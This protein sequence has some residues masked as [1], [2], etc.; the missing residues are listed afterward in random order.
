MT[1]KSHLFDLPNELFFQI[2][3]HL[4]ASELIESF[5]NLQSTRLRS[6]LSSFIVHLDLSDRPD[7]WLNEY[8]PRVLPE[9]S[10][11]SLRCEDRQINRLVDS[12]SAMDLLRSMEIRNSD[13][14]TDL[15]KEALDRVRQRLKQLKIIFTSTHGQGDIAQHLFQ[16]DASI[17][18][19]I[20]TGRFLYFQPNELNR[21]DRLKSLGIELEDMQHL[22]L[23][24]QHLPQLEELKVKFRSEKRVF[25]SHLSPSKCFSTSPPLRRVTFAGSSKY[26]DQFEPFFA[27]FG[28]TIEA[29]SIHMDLMYYTI[30]GEHF[31][32]ILLKNMPN[33]SSL[34]LIMHSSTG[35]A[36][37]ARILSFQSS[38]WQRF[39]PIVYW[40]DARAHQQT[41]FTL[42]YQSDR[43]S[44]KRER[45]S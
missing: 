24:L 2:F 36:D 43:V 5:F 31:E 37:P 7:H 17:E 22:F 1:M 14:T 6:L 27:Q 33:L 30:D 39:D 26:F 40:F 9:Y 29:L 3:Q 8:L 10:V 18:H 13:W 25:Q 41:I 21:T 34:N 45:R 12:F 11:E 15:L 28:S 44:R 20:V 23:L 4:S 32:Q 42:P 38:V 35:H 16:S 19:L